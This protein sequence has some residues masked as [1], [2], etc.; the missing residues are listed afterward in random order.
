M[1]WKAKLYLQME[2]K[3]NPYIHFSRNLYQV[4]DKHTS[5][6]NDNENKINVKLWKNKEFMKQKRKRVKTLEDN[7]LKNNSKKIVKYFLPCPNRL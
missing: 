6:N 1:F 3:N 4:K 2:F 7:K 5:F